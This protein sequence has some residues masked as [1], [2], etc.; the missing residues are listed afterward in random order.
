MAGEY[1]ATSRHF[2]Y[3]V[4]A[5]S[6]GSGI[7]DVNLRISVV[8]DDM[9]P[10][11]ERS[12]QVWDI[13]GTDV[14]ATVKEFG[15]HAVI[16]PFSYEEDTRSGLRDFCRLTGQGSDLEELLFEFLR[17]PEIVVPVYGSAPS[18]LKTLR[19]VVED[20]GSQAALIVGP[21][22]AGFASDNTSLP[23]LLL[24]YAGGTIVVKVVFPV[25]DE[26]GEDLL[27]RFGSA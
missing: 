3:T 22:A 12:Q 9:R 11:L 19:D 4:S 27:T 13:L 18:A 7:A 25:L 20:A 1:V 2:A 10:D 14:V 16:P 6:T 26:L 17:G 8:E 21:G 15:P 5:S 23:A 24:L